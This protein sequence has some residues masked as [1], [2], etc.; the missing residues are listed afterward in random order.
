MCTGAQSLAEM[1]MLSVHLWGSFHPC[2]RRLS[3]GKLALGSPISPVNNSSPYP[4]NEH[5][6]LWFLELDFG[7]IIL[8]SWWQTDI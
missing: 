7:G 5:N 6:K 4:L 8:V 2:W 1:S 3:G